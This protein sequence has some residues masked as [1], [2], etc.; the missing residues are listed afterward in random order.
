MPVLNTIIILPTIFVHNGPES[1]ERGDDQ[2]QA[3]SGY[4]HEFMFI[5]DDWCFSHSVAIAWVVVIN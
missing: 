4:N 1:L 3:H 2:S 5:T